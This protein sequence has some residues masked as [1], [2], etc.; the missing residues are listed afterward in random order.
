MMNLKFLFPDGTRIDYA[1]FI[2]EDRLP[3]EEALALE[4]QKVFRFFSQKVSRRLQQMDSMAMQRNE[5]VAE[6]R[7][8]V[9]FQAG[10]AFRLDED[11]QR[12]VPDV[13][14]ALVTDL[15]Q[16]RFGRER[17]YTKAMR[18]AGISRQ[19]FATMMATKNQTETRRENILRLA[20]ALEASPE[21][22]E[23][24]LNAKG[25]AFRFTNHSDIVVRYCMQHGI[26]SHAAVDSLLHSYGCPTLFSLE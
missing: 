5:T 3:D 11:L 12:D 16:R 19:L 18:A 9:R 13:F 23:E 22:T 21:E 6:E 10:D 2:D 26:T 14:P 15:I 8:E 4:M 17:G 25:Y 20:F 24:L 1:R 7:I